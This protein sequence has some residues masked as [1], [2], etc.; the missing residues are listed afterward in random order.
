MFSI[1]LFFILLSDA[2][3]FLLHDFLLRPDMRA[4]GARATRRI[5]R[6]NV[7]HRPM[8]HVPFSLSA[9]RIA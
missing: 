9:L 7:L 5:V 3:S 4:L 2:L 6:R 1:G 8:E